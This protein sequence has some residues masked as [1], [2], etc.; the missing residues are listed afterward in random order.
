MKFMKAL[1]V[2]GGLNWGLVGVA[3]LFGFGNWNVINLILGSLPWLE[4]LVYLLVG[5]SALMMLKK[6]GGKCNKGGMPEMKEEK[7]GMGGDMGHSDANHHK[8]D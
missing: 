4:N 2:I 5:L 8:V 1:V 6:C 7:M 3:G